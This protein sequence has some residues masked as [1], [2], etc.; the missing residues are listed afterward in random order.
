MKYDTTVHIPSQVDSLLLSFQKADIPAME[1]ALDNIRNLAITEKNKNFKKALDEYKA[2]KQQSTKR[3]EEEALAG[4]K[5]IL[6]QSKT[7]NEIFVI[8]ENIK[9]NVVIALE[10]LERDYWNNIKE[11][12]LLH[13]HEE[14]KEEL[15]EDVEG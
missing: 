8:I 14:P 2:K 6:Q 13:I 5:A 3:I 7:L 12:T 4:A 15:D 9:N 11:I 10:E 1:R